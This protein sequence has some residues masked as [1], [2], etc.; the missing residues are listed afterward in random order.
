MALIFGVCGA[1][2]TEELPR[3]TI[4]DIKDHNDLYLVTVRGTGTNLTR[5]FTIDG[6]FYKTVQKYLD[7]RPNNVH[8]DRAFLNYQN[9]KC[10]TQVIGKNKFG[11]MPKEIAKFLNLPD[12]D[13]YTGH[14]FRKTSNLLASSSLSRRRAMNHH[15]TSS[16]ILNSE[17][18]SEYYE[19]LQKRVRENSTFDSGNF[20]D[21]EFFFLFI[22]I[23]SEICLICDL[24]SFQNSWKS[25]QKSLTRKIL[26]IL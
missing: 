12:S 1:C 19:P 9:G 7:M 23:R 13:S 20:N 18:T 11:R 21:C 26:T 16:S 22:L 5:S 14:S 3:I 24:Y 4:N 10:T 8:T 15:I 6:D 2:R 17:Q 25:R